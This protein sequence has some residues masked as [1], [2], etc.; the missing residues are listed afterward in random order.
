ML[1]QVQQI[2]IHSA[3]YVQDVASKGTILILLGLCD[4]FLP[5][6]DFVRLSVYSSAIAVCFSASKQH[7]VRSQL[8]RAH[9]DDGKSRRTQLE[10]RKGRLEGSVRPQV[11]EGRTL[12]G[13]VAAQV[14][15]T[16]LLYLIGN[17]RER[18]DERAEGPK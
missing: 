1:K 17:G 15:G 3:S 16:W 2:T 5:T 12:E 8:L 4:V 6:T 13:K 18:G 10:S 9:G 14:G 7:L 11:D